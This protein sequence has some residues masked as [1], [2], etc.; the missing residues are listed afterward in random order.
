ME[1]AIRVAVVG[2]GH[3]GREHARVYSTSG[4]ASLVAVCD[5]NETVAAEAARRFGVPAVVDYHDLAGKVDAVSVAV[6]TVQHHH[7]AC[8]FLN[9]GISVLVEKPIALTLTEAGQMID[10]A[11]RN[12]A[13]LQV[14]HLERFNPAVVSAEAMVTQPR[15]FE[16]D[17]KS[18]RLNSSHSDRS[19]MP[20]SA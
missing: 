6:P 19:R 5:S 18:T 4:N 7:V 12:G 11:G 17:R 3:F 13:V 14:G 8:D 10:A 20:S 15:F 9:A 16:A 2:A 1:R